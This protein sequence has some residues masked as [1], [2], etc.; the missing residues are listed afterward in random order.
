M[1]KE[2]LMKKMIANKMKDVPKEEQERILGIIEKN[3]ELFMKIA[4][5]IQEKVKAGKDQMEASIEV[6]KA[7]ETELKGIAKP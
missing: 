7:H 4:A 6:M 3:P 1:L 2:F 5:E